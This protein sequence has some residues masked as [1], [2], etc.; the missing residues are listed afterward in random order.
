MIRKD[1]RKI[2]AFF[3]FSLAIARISGANTDINPDKSGENTDISQGCETSSNNK[4]TALDPFDSTPPSHTYKY[5]KPSKISVTTLPK[6]I[7]EALKNHPSIEADKEALSASDDVI[8]QAQAGYMPSVDLRV[9]VGRDNFR[10]NFNANPLSPLDSKGSLSTTRNDPSITI[11]QILFDG[12]GIA[13][14]I[15]RARS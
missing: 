14:R 12:M 13:S 11:R 5:N 7:Q 10:R 4:A 6:I 3:V 15:D 8:D 2:N 1:L 9:S